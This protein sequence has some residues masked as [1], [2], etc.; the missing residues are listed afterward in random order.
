MVLRAATKKQ[1]RLLG[2]LRLRIFDGRHRHARIVNHWHGVQRVPVRICLDADALRMTRHLALLIH[3]IANDPLVKRER[4]LRMTFV[5]AAASL[6][7]VLATKHNHRHVITASEVEA[8]KSCLGMRTATGHRSIR[9]NIVP[10]TDNC[11]ILA[12]HAV[13]VQHRLGRAVFGFAASKPQRVHSVTV[14]CTADTRRYTR[15]R[16]RR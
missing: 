11:V 5:V 12:F 1:E 13:R 10:N 3:D 4:I 6:V 2:V 8:G 16:I 14:R 9:A 7:P 15:C